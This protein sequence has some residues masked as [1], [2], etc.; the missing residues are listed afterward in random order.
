MN[1]FVDTSVVLSVM[2]GQKGDASV[3]E[4][5]E[6]TYVS[7]LLKIEYFRSLDRL[8]LQSEI[9]DLE[10]TRLVHIFELFWTNC[11][12]IPMSKK[13]LHR[14]AGAFPTV[15]ATLDAI[16]LSTALAVKES[17]ES[18]LVLLTHDRQLKMAARA[19]GLDVE[20]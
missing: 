16:H 6:N 8:R 13:I 19:S 18:N 1:A 14:A 17:L 12:E 2:L 10:R 5:W 11:N 4:K 20:E 9:D 15:I 3:L 7:E